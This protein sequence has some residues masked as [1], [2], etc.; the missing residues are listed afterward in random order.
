MISHVQ[1]TDLVNIT[2]QKETKT[3]FWERFFSLKERSIN[4]YLD[5]HPEALVNELDEISRPATANRRSTSLMSSQ[6]AVSR[7]SDRPILPAPALEMTEAVVVRVL[8]VVLEKGEEDLV[9]LRIRGNAICAPF[10]LQNMHLKTELSGH[11]SASVK[12]S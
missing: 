2:F 9:R 12:C 5:I 7:S 10:V 11:G 8:I 1:L 3:S 6:T 4:D